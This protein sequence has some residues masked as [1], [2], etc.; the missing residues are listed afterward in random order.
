VTVGNGSSAVT[1]TQQHSR[2]VNETRTFETETRRFE[3]KTETETTAL[4]TETET[5]ILE[6][7]LETETCLETTV[8]LKLL[9]YEKLTQSMILTVVGRGSVAFLAILRSHSP[10][11]DTKAIKYNN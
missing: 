10:D 9:W 8:I 5:K 1:H 7:G 2:D 11:G 6:T 3:T 4:E